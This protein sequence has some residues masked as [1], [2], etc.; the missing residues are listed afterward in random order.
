[1]GYAAADFHQ[2]P[3]LD[4]FLILAD[5]VLKALDGSARAG[6]PSPSRQPLDDRMTVAERREAGAL[7]RVNHVGEV[8][9]QALYSAQ[10]LATSNP[11]LRQ[12]YTAAAREETDHLAWTR[13]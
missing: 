4:R 1:M 10:A 13:Q 5:G 8:C 11:A 2:T 7:M 3:V 12:H 6:R 9:A